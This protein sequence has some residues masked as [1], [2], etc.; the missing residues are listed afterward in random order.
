M[1][2]VPLV[3]KLTD[4]LNPWVVVLLAASGQ[5]AIAVLCLGTA[6]LNLAPVIIACICVDIFHQSN[7]I[8]Q[9]GRIYAYVEFSFLRISV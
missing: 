6:A 4:R 1:F 7:T 5:T 8:G 9:Q 3:G 2:S